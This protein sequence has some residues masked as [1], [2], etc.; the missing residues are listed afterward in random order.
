MKNVVLRFWHAGLLGVAALLLVLAVLTAL[1]TGRRMT[2]R[3]KW[4][5]NTYEVIALTSN[6]V[7]LIKD[8]DSEQ[9]SFIVTG[10]EVYREAFTAVRAQAE[11][12]AA[13]HRA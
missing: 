6:A 7:S 9:R 4:V 3:V 8:A 5:N 10:S 13:E 11:R 1:L 2:E 12:P